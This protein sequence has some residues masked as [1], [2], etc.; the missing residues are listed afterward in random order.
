MVDIVTIFDIFRLTRVFYFIILIT[1]RQR[2]LKQFVYYI[3]IAD[4]FVIFSERR[5]RILIL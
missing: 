5:Q 2:K 1:T 3:R 4:N